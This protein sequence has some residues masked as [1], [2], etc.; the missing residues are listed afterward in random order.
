[1]KLKD[2]QSE[3]LIEE[4]ENGPCEEHGESDPES[5]PLY[6]LII[7]TWEQGDDLKFCIGETESLEEALLLQAN[8]YD[9]CARIFRR[10]ASIAENYEN[11]S[12]CEETGSHF[13]GIH[14]DE[15]VMETLAKEEL[16][17]PFEIDIEVEPEPSDEELQ[18][19]FEDRKDKI[20]H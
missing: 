19:V 6:Q 16:V 2:I 3:Q 11:F 9:E 15:K 10:L 13:I 18:K 20:I 8:V 1:M 14:G 12:V 4:L 7:P 17:V 5:Q